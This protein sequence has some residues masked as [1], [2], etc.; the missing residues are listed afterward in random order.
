VA[1]GSSLP[2]RVLHRPRLGF[3][4]TTAALV[5]LA[6]GG[7]GLLVAHGTRQLQPPPPHALPPPAA[8][9]PS[10]PVLVDRPPGSLTLPPSHVNRTAPATHQVVVAAP[11]P[12]PPAV[13]VAP[14]AVAPPAVASPPPVVVVP[15]VSP[16]A[17]PPPVVE[18]AGQPDRKHAK[19]KP[20]PAHPGD[21]GK[22]L[23]QLKKG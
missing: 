16:P 1:D 23:G 5:A 13:S 12:H 20:H 10:L 4:V 18:P 6:S 8:T 11:R 15:P 2:A 9:P 22:H 19:K 21:N 17:E 14:P 3:G 7:T